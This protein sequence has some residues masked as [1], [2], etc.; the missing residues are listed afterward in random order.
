[1]SNPKIL[2]QKY[3]M[4]LFISK[5]IIIVHNFITIRVHFIPIKAGHKPQ[6]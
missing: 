4:L 5:I 6:H 2:K 1:M 3:K